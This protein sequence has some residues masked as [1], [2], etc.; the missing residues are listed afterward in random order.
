MSILHKLG[1]AAQSFRYMLPSKHS[2]RVKFS[3]VIC[4]LITALLGVFL[5]VAQRQVESTLLEAGGQRADT[6]AD[7]LASMLPQSAQQRTTETQRIAADSAVRR[8]LKQP[9]DS[10]AREA[11]R[12]RLVSAA[13][14]RSVVTLWDSASSRLLEVT[15]TAASQLSLPAD[16]T[17]SRAG[18]TTFQVA[19][20]FVFFDVVAEVVETPTLPTTPFAPRLGYVVA[21]RSFSAAPTSD[22]LRQVLGTG[23]VIK[24][25]NQVG[26]VWTNFADVVP[27]PPVVG[28]HQEFAE[29]RTADG[30][31]HLV[32][33]TTERG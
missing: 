32:A 28:N 11:A 1:E 14:R 16:P 22:M 26:G 15:S 23:A 9:T 31:Q 21:R 4:A 5:S 19:G 6:A 2:L 10:I 33:R 25:G 27:A 20:N 8:Y 24:I 7:L 30:Q 17:P 3:L 12:Q 29:F 18:L 13:T